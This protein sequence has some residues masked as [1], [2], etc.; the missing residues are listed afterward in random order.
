MEFTQI[1][2][3]KSGFPGIPEGLQEAG[4]PAPGAGWA[5]YPKTTVFWRPRQAEPFCGCLSF[6]L[7]LGD[8]LVPL[9][10][11]HPERVNGDPEPHSPQR[12]LPLD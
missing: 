3:Q 10:E 11:L 5:G 1:Q 9:G 2:F 4:M 6:P 8:G 12:P 7:M